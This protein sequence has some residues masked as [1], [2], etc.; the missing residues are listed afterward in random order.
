MSGK[1][2]KEIK[3]NVVAVIAKAEEAEVKAEKKPAVDTSGLDLPEYQSRITR[4]ADGQT[5][6][7]HNGRR[8][9]WTGGLW[10]D[11]ITGEALPPVASGPQLAVRVMDPAGNYHTYRTANNHYL[12]DLMKSFCRDASLDFGSV[13]FLFDGRRL[14]PDDSAQSV[15]LEDGDAI[16]VFQEQTGGECSSK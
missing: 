2:D 5:Y 14:R 16:E 11:V 6:L 10:V 13:R 7:K 15:G 3:P 9:R 1:A 8:Y 4:E 12:E